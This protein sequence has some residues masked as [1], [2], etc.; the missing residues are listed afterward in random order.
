MADKHENLILAIK[1]MTDKAG[2]GWGDRVGRF[3]EIVKDIC[4]HYSEHLD[5][6]PLEIFN[7]LEKKRNYSYPN[8]YQWSNFPKLDDIMIFKT[9]GDMLATI[10]PKDGFRCPACLGKSTGPNI[11]DSGIEVKKK[12]CDW[13]SYGLFG[14]LGKGMSILVI[15]NWIDN[16]VVFEIF[17][18]IALEK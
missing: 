9:K 13:K 4:V 12:K 17:M 15:E 10:K 14:T 8:Y 7:A 18:P 6:E 11:C 5:H 3:I 16:P 1:E 2:N